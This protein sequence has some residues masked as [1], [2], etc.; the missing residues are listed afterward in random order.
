MSLLNKHL[1]IS[2]FHIFL[3]NAYFINFFKISEH[4]EALRQRI[5]I[6]DREI[7]STKLPRCVF[8]FI[9]FNYS[10]VDYCTYRNLQIARPLAEFRRG[11]ESTNSFRTHQQ[12]NRN[13]QGLS[14][15]RSDSIN[16][17]IKSDWIKS[18]NQIKSNH[19]CSRARRSTRRARRT[20]R[21]STSWAWTRAPKVSCRASTWTGSES[22]WCACSSRRSS[23]A[24]CSTPTRRARSRS[25]ART[26]RS[27]SSTR[28]SF[29]QYIYDNWIIDSLQINNILRIIAGAKS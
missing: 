16:K 1:F 15:I 25:C 13:A 7:Q 2:F 18:L 9:Y 20:W 6:L 4:S 19:H 8:A 21:S 10:I 17:I 27:C 3:R 28:R 14:R 29:D 12:A 23:A 24:S 5:L 26:T 22:R 11:L